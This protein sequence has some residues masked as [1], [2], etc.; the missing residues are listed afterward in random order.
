MVR[1]KFAQQQGVKI[2]FKGFELKDEAEVCELKQNMCESKN[3]VNYSK[4]SKIKNK[5]S[6]TDSVSVEKNMFNNKASKSKPMDVHG[7][8][9]K[10]ERSQ[11]DSSEE[12]EKVLSLE[13]EQ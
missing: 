4:V 2:G 8:K 5:K 9:E 11:R 13:T 10:H 3:Q 7:S 12:K 6:S 1:L